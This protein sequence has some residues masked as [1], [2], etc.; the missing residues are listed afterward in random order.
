[1]SAVD[2][3]CGLVGVT[4]TVLSADAIVTNKEA[5]MAAINVNTKNRLVFIF[6][7]SSDELYPGPQLTRASGGKREI[8]RP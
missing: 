2:Q 5:I 8:N 6:S 7:P 3:P 1:V 4:T